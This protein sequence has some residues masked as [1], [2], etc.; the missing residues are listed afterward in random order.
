[1][2]D[3]KVVNSKDK[4]FIDKIAVH[5]YDTSCPIRTN[6]EGRDQDAEDYRD[7]VRIYAQGWPGECH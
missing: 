1:M 4:Y 3:I 2:P 7:L 5:Y 6:E